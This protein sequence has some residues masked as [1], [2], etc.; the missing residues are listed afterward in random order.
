[1][2][3]HFLWYAVFVNYLACKVLPPKMSY[4]QRKQFLHDARFYQWNDPLLFRRCADQVVRRCVLEDEYE[5]ILTHCHSSPHGSHFGATKTAQKV[6]HCGFHWLSLIRDY[7]TFV[8]RCDRYQRVGNILRRNQM[9]LNNMLEGK[10]FYVW[11]I[12]FM[13]QFPSS[14]GNLYIL[15]VVDY[16]SKW[17]EAIATPKNDAK[18]VPKFL[19]K[20]IFTRLGTSRAIISDG[21]SHFCNK[22]FPTLMAK[23]GVNHRKSLE[24]HPQANSQAEISNRKLK[25]ILEKTVNTNRKDWSLRLDDSL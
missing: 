14:C 12:D 18:T 3:T 9:P 13:G 6:L 1:M 19:H 23:Y 8:K 16:V 2:G 20:N 7:F 10:I 15:L 17:V 24:Y 11:G 25:S 4:R 21:G 5:A 22:V